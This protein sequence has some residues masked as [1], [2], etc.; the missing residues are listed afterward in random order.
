VN[1]VELNLSGNRLSA[2]DGLDTLQALVS[3]DVSRNLIASV[4]EVAKLS[5]N[6][7]LATLSLEG[8]PLANKT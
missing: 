6:K 2:L 4:S 5:R 3:L 8:N 7:S 1:L